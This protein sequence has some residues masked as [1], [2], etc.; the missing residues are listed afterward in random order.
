MPRLAALPCLAVLL[1]AATARADLPGYVAKADGAF[2]W[3]LKGKSATPLGTVYDLRLVSQV[4][5][6]IKW[7]HGLQV[8]VPAGV[9]PTATIFLWNQGGNP[10]AGSAAFGLTL[11]G[12]MQAP[13]AFLFGIPNQ[14]LL[15]GKK[16]D[17]LIAETFVRFLATQDE[18]WPLLFPMVKSLV[19]AM[20]ALQAFAKQEWQREVT[21]FVVSGGSK[22]GWTSWLTAAA[23]RRVKAIA[24]LVIDTLNFPE[25]LPHQLKSFGR[26][27]EMIHDYT[28]RGLVPMPDTPPARKLW[29]M[30]DPFAYRDTLTMPKLLVLGT[31]DRYWTVDALN[32]YWGGL[33]GDKWVC[34][35]PNAGHNLQ[36]KSAD[37]K[38]DMTRAVD[39]L[40]A[41]GRAQIHGLPLPALTWAH[42]DE[43][44][45]H[46]VTVKTPT[47]P[48]GARVWVADAP[49]RDFRPA[50]WAEAPA[51]VNGGTVTAAVA[52][53]KTG[54]RAFFVELDYDLDGQPYRL[55]TQLRVTAPA[56]K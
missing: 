43:N 38:A 46:T 21:G 35:V 20:D 11:A 26:Y 6:G 2:A 51:A 17:A 3:E 7:E 30:T 12:K 49:T 53:P 48:I 44:G 13:V 29:Q 23:D 18:D 56:G 39:A 28:E 41:F 36:Q 8:Y 10:S 1:T 25:Q 19:R 55:S 33:K 50:P 9:A 31:N 45:K 15:G 22:R 34:Y 4:W 47:T 42:G 27:S 37:G 24:P 5:Q 40:G 54:Y 32:L 16:E 52:P 14:P